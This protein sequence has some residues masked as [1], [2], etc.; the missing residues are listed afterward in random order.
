MY[1][2]SYYQW[3]C[4]HVKAF[5]GY[6][7]YRL[8]CPSGESSCQYCV[9]GSLCSWWHECDDSLHNEWLSNVT[10]SMCSCRRAEVFLAYYVKCDNWP[11]LFAGEDWHWIKWVSALLA[12]FPVWLQV[13]YSAQLHFCSMP[14]PTL[15]ALEIRHWRKTWPHVIGTELRHAADLLSNLPEARANSWP[16]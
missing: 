15:L 5:G 6:S 8:P 11:Q 2:A 10:V 1:T 12:S 14:P 4:L 13:L 3:R 16:P 9:H 7:S